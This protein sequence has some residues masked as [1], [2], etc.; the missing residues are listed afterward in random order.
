MLLEASKEASQSLQGCPQG[1]VAGFMC[2]PAEWWPAGV[3]IFGDDVWLVKGPAGR[4]LS[5]Q[6]IRHGGGE[7]SFVAL[8]SGL[9]QRSGSEAF[10]ATPSAMNARGIPDCFAC[11]M[12]AP[13]PD[14]EDF[15]LYLAPLDVVGPCR[16]LFSN[17][18]L[19]ALEAL[20]LA[21][22]Q[23][24]HAT[25]V[26]PLIANAVWRRYGQAAAEELRA[27]GKATSIYSFW[28]EETSCGLRH[29]SKTRFGDLFD[30]HALIDRLQAV[31]GIRGG[32]SWHEFVEKSQ[33][34]LDVLATLSD[35]PTAG[36]GG[37]PLP[38]SDEE[39]T[40]TQMPFFDTDFAVSR[41]VCVRSTAASHGGGFDLRF[42]DMPRLATAV[43]GAVAQAKKEGRRWA[44]VGLFL[45][46]VE[47]PERARLHPGRYGQL[48][49]HSE[50]TSIW[51]GLKFAPSILRR[52]AGIADRLNL[53][54]ERYL[55]AHWRQG[56]W[57]L[58]PHPRK[59]EQAE[60]AQAPRFAAVIRRHLR[61][62]GLT[63]LF[64]MTNAPAGGEDVAALTAELEG[65]QVVQAPVL[66]GDRHNLR[67]LCAE[68]AIASSA[69]FFLA[70]GD[71]IVQGMASMPS[72]LVLQ[73]RLHSI[74]WPLDS[75]AFSFVQGNFQD[76]L[77]L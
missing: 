71:G 43:R 42:I 38:C 16:E 51:Q 44:S 52:A 37:V 15:T 36:D 49:S 5:D 61:E 45:Y 73:M 8:S 53:R 18:L 77:G 32:T 12:L 9:F 19:D 55:A 68:M 60:L 1:E 46:W 2:A 11:E 28:K 25:L 30:W 13:K 31:R 23:G 64:L 66:Q 6:W 29:G 27:S 47:G 63:R 3:D 17:L 54:G 72:L 39:Q 62:R 14:E 4:L 69:E 7:A 41:R 40:V 58:G 75:N 20:Q 35:H 70:F 34:K 74:G 26:E 22:F 10:D 24:P 65:V 57:F 56:D 76:T 21:S 59:L 33:G 50:Y 48:S 67:Q